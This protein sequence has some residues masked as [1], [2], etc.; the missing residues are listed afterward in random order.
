M[1]AEAPAELVLVIEFASH[2]SSKWVMQKH[3]NG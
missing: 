1:A 3:T 2:F